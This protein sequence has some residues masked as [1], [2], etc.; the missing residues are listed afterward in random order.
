GNTLEPPY[1]AAWNNPVAEEYYFDDYVE[2]GFQTV[3]LP[4]RWDNHTNLSPPYAISEAWMDRV[5]EIVDWGLSRGLMVILNTHHDDWIKQDFS[6]S[7]QARFDSIWAQV[8]TRFADK[9]EKLLME[10]INEPQGLTREEIDKLNPRVLRII[11]RTNPTRIVIYSGAGWAS[12]VDLFAAAIP[13]DDYLMGYYHSYDPWDFAGLANGGWGSTQ[14]RSELRS[15]VQAVASWSN[16]TGMPVMLSEFGV[17]HGAS[18]N[19]RMKYYAA[20]VEE[21]IEAGIPTQVWDD[22]GDFGI[23]NRANRTWPEVKDILISTYPDG[24]TDLAFAIQNDSLVVVSW[25]NRYGLAS[26]IS[27]QRAPARGAFETI[28]EISGTATSFEDSDVTGGVAYDYRV[29]A[30]VVQGPDRFSYPQRFAVPAFAR[31]AFGGTPALIP[32]SIEAEDYDVGGEGLTYHDSDDINTP[33]G[34]RPTAGVDI[35]ARD[36]GGWQLSYVEAGEW[37]E[38][39]VD[40]QTAGTYSITAHVASLEGSGRFRLSFDAVG[41]P[42]FVAANTGSWQTTEPVSVLTDLEA[43]EQVMRLDIRTSKPFNIDRF[44]ITLDTATGVEDAPGDFDL[45]LYPNPVE[46]QLTISGPADGRAE[47]IDMLGRRVSEHHLAGP[48]TRINTTGLPAGLYL[49]RITP[50]RGSVRNELFVRR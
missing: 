40:V 6:D 7:N 29:I 26:G 20:V 18:H 30:R 43:G 38:Y 4:V 33:G 48:E 24:P 45:A 1:E 8:A 21:T 12:A 14:E 34:Y 5:E 46:T 23:Y 37:L 49:M 19:D 41:A 2:A 15:R 13:D 47:I 11:R 32:G 31:S 3:R 27:V 16:T 25:T 35:E 9:S 10:I 42:S 17:V 39:S 44:D 36:V 22:G 28:A 50:A